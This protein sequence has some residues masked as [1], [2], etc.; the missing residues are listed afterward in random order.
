MDNCEKFIAHDCKKEQL[1][2]AVKNECLRMV[3]VLAGR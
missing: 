3:Y 2:W 1:K